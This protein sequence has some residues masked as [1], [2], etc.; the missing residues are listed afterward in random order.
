MRSW[1]QAAIPAHT[2]A[3]ARAAAQRALEVNARSFRAFLERATADLIAA[4][5][6]FDR[7]LSPLPALDRADESVA[8]A[9]GLNPTET[10]CFEASASLAELRQR[11]L[12]R[13]GLDGT[14]AA[15]A[16][17]EVV[18]RGLATNPQ[19][20]RLLASKGTL[21]WLAGRGSTTTETRRDAASRAELAWQQA[22]ALNP[23]L[24]REIEPFRREATASR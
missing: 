19:A 21:T 8:R 20:P 16:G 15:V 24:A 11:W 17:L 3:A 7:Q 1:R 14:A 18:E 23:L 6:A 10:E 2:F 9:L 13:Q 12:G 5:W 22:L 4:S